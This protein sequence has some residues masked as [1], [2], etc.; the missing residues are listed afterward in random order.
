LDS[1]KDSGGDSDRWFLFSCCFQSD[2]G[3]V[4]KH[5]K[6][7]AETFPVNWKVVSGSGFCSLAV[8]PACPQITS[9][10][11]LC[12]KR[13]P[14]RAGEQP[15]GDV[16]CLPFFFRTFGSLQGDWQM[17]S[18]YQSCFFSLDWKATKS[19]YRIKN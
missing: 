10:V 3:S 1:F 15:L 11:L 2:I 6:K 4:L 12:P 17:L 18:S 5:N 8:W 19:W 13:C 7:R 9:E 14:A 16:W